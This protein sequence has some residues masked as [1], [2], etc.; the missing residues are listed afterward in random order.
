M[1]NT[2]TS[3]LLTD[4]L[5][6]EVREEI[7][8]AKQI[9]EHQGIAERLTELIGTPIT[10]SLKMLPGV[11]EEALNTAIEKSLH[12]AL[13]VAVKTLG[14]DRDNM[15]KPKLLTHK[16][17]AG[18]SGA[19]GGALG[20]ATVAAELPVSTVLILRSVADIARSQGEDLAQLETRLSCLEVF[21]FDPQAMRE[22][23]RQ[24]EN[25]PGTIKDATEVGYFAV[26]AAM[27]KQ[28]AAASK[29]VVNNSILETTA[30]PLVRLI[31]MI[32]KRFG[33]VVSQKVAAQAIP[34]IGAVGGALINSY[35][36]D[37]YQDLARAH[38]TIRRLERQYGDAVVR[39]AYHSA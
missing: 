2:R 37:H 38:F 19:A 11:A 14:R 28:V 3:E 12:M 39:E 13:D 32:S 33:V 30:P 7:R 35:F 4:S 10:A 21:A 31:A 18:V 25:E 27:A 24:A 22:V 23:S 26:R 16:I 15:S 17:L 36:I 5:P 29:Y 9:L 8:E 34:V 20:G 1:A 6:P